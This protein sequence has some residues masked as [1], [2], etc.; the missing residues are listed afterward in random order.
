VRA[1][2]SVGMPCLVTAANQDP[3]G[4]AINA[5]LQEACAQHAWVFSLG[6]GVDL[7]HQAMHHADAMVGN[8]SSGII[9]AASLGLPVVNIGERQ[10]GRERSG[11]V[12][13][14]AHDAEAIERAIRGAIAMDRD[15]ITNVYGAPDDGSNLSASKRIA[16]AIA[17]MP[18]GAAGQRNLF[19]P[20]GLGT[21]E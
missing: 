9:E 7:Y 5:A 10:G 11:N 2:G 6:L 17:A 16:R 13:D 21:S 18:L 19:E 1:L 4:D 14:C 8:S 3:A 20:P 15:A 12:V